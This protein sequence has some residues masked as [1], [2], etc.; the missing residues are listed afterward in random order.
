MTS[1]NIQLLTGLEGIT[2]LILLPDGWYGKPWDNLYPIEHVNITSS[3]IFLQADYG[4][5]LT[6]SGDPE[7][8]ERSACI[9]FKIDGK[10][11]FR[12]SDTGKT[13]TYQSGTVTIVLPAEPATQQK[14]VDEHFRVNQF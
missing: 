5:S 11:T 14:C 8:Q 10:A 13:R 9:H 7:I 4:I 3:E 1:F 6:F 12:D 2:T